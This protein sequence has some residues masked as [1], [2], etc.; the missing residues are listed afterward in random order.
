MLLSVVGPWLEPGSTEELGS[1]RTE[2]VSRA[3]DV[4][5][6]A[7][8]SSGC[9]KQGEHKEEAGGTLGL[10]I[11]LCGFSKEF[12]QIQFSHP[13]EKKNRICC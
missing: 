9:L 2:G 12:I 4:L 10:G 5:W 8:S 11:D 7:G 1:A 6:Q 3:G 13:N